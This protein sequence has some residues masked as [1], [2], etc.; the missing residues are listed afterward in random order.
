M[1]TVA[2]FDSCKKSL[3]ESLRHNESLTAQLKLT[4][5]D[6]RKAQADREE[7]IQSR[8]AMR[9]EGAR[10]H[11]ELEA[12]RRRVG[13]LTAE[14]QQLMH[15]KLSLQQQLKAEQ[16]RHDASASGTS[17]LRQKLQDAEDELL[18]ARS[19]RDMLRSRVVDGQTALNDAMSVADR[20]RV[21]VDMTRR[22]A[23]SE[24]SA[25]HRALA[26]DFEELGRRRQVEREVWETQRTELLKQRKELE[27]TTT[28]RRLQARSLRCTAAQRLV[29]RHEG[30]VDAVLRILVVNGWWQMCLQRRAARA[31]M[32]ESALRSASDRAADATTRYRA[33]LAWRRGVLHASRQRRLLHLVERVVL[34]AEIAGTRLLLTAVVFAWAA[35]TQRKEE[36]AVTASREILG[37]SE[38][39]SA[40]VALFC[41]RDVFHLLKSSCRAWAAMVMRTTF[42]RRAVRTTAS[43][44]GSGYPAATKVAAFLVWKVSARADLRQRLKITNRADAVETI[45]ARESKLS[46]SQ[47]ILRL[48]KVEVSRGMMRRYFK[49][50]TLSKL[51][52]ITTSQQE[53][54]E[55][56]M[57]QYVFQKWV[58]AH[59]ALQMQRLM[60]A[61]EYE[62]QVTAWIEYRQSVSLYC[63]DQTHLKFTKRLVFLGW[64]QEVRLQHCLQRFGKYVQKSQRTSDLLE[65]MGAVKLGC[66]PAAKGGK[67]AVQVAL[68]EQRAY[69]EEQLADQRES[70]DIVGA[71]LSE[72]A[73]R[74]GK[75]FDLHDFLQRHALWV[76]RI[77]DSKRHLE[78]VLTRTTQ[79]LAYFHDVAEGHV[80]V[81]A[82]TDAGSTWAPSQSDLSTAVGVA[83]PQRPASARPPSGRPLSA[84]ALAARPTSASGARPSPRQGDDGSV[85]R[86]PDDDFRKRSGTLNPKPVGLS[87]LAF[88]HRQ[89][90]LESRGPAAG[91]PR[92]KELRIV[93]A[94]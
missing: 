72:M 48:W 56:A 7:L 82:S 68:D 73:R 76:C 86:S 36:Q 31:P 90:G 12:L 49:L 4:E 66:Q 25:K 11:G 29:S 55:S 64:T 92:R 17:A 19:E 34:A 6:L 71:G 1:A 52:R 45:W 8:G 87:A 57:M 94:S 80:P 70:L 15:D 59:D 61:A 35:E 21:E 79:Q 91:V 14:A 84:K 47:Q 22:D 63:W 67:R 74:Q 41:K 38:S 44:V 93:N 53:L 9:M 50:L 33:V 78:E 13:I 83:T 27:S 77:A 23:E 62:K 75:S 16:Q 81:D 40:A 20:L 43:C 2:N 54:R 26:R 39:R 18:E 10:E 51:L 60:E 88:E 24:L 28:R 42:T 30:R 3:E 89:D 85:P 32:K 69:Y 58:E 46:L 5:E 37:V 65:A